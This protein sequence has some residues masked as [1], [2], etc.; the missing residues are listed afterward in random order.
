MQSRFMLA[1][2]ENWQNILSRVSHVEGDAPLE[3]RPDLFRRCPGYL[4]LFIPHLRGPSSNMDLH[5]LWLCLGKYRL[6][7]LLR[8]AM[9]SM[10]GAVHKFQCAL[11]KPSVRFAFFA[12]NRR[13]PCQ[14]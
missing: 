11:G 8:T 2:K 3:V 5:S 4:Q 13:D 6:S 1:W 12:V 10:Q 9:P 7:N 14:C